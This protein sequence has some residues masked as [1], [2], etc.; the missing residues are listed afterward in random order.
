MKPK[1]LTLCLALDLTLKMPVRNKINSKLKN[2]SRNTQYD[3]E[4]EG[5]RWNAGSCLGICY[6]AQSPV[7]VYL[8]DRD[9]GDSV[10]P[11]SVSFRVFRGPYF[12][13][14]VFRGPI[15]VLLS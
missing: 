15:L 11:F 2:C 6:P 7:S 8:Q 10:P 9:D 14:F 3:T 4:N 12:R 5:T 1:V 13:V